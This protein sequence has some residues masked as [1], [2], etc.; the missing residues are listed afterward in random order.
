[1]LLDT[2]IL[3]L[4]VR[5][6]FPLE[7]EVERHRPG[8][9]LGVPTSVLRELDRLIERATPGA[10]AACALARHFRAVPASG[11][12]DGAVVKAAVRTGAWVVTADRALRIRLNAAGVGVLAPRDRHRLEPYPPRA[13]SAPSAD[14]RPPNG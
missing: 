1:M 6:G 3:F 8:A 14:R 4:P 12:G 7:S 10:V 9:V 11:G 13:P 2:N 5:T